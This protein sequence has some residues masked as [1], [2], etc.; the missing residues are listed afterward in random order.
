MT[1]GIDVGRLGVGAAMLTFV[2][3]R[4][5]IG[6]SQGLGLRSIGSVVLER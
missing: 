2:L 4:A 5:R 3:A 1:S 6:V